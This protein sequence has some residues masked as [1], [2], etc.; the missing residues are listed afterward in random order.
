M[1]AK[2]AS[3]LTADELI[4]GTAIAAKFINQNP[5]IDESAIDAALTDAYAKGSSADE[6]EMR[7]RVRALLGLF[8]SRSNYQKYRPRQRLDVMAR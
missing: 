4:A 1:W 5:G 3:G 6:W 7:V 8:L 2:D